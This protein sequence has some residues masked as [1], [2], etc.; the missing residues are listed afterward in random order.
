MVT[1]AAE[2]INAAAVLCRDEESLPISDL[3]TFLVEYRV[4]LSP[5]DITLTIMIYTVNQ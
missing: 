3:S 4:G 5:Q 1:A 2:V